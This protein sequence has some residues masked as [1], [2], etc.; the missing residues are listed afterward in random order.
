MN[1][2]IRYLEDS[3][4]DAMK[5]F[6]FEPEWKGPIITMNIDPNKVIPKEL[7][8]NGANKKLFKIPL[9]TNNDDPADMVKIDRIVAANTDSSIET[10]AWINEE[11]LIRIELGMGVSISDVVLHKKTC[12]TAKEGKETE[13]VS[14]AIRENVWFC[15]L[16]GIPWPIQQVSGRPFDPEKMKRGGEFVHS[17]E[18]DSAVTDQLYF[19]ELDTRGRILRVFQVLTAEDID[20]LLKRKN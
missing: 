18:V 5:R 17:S 1:S 8:G 6:G 7:R 20:V 13:I 19:R 10:K 4:H 14:K 11:S 2:L 16:N 12:L 9:G 15:L 3:Q